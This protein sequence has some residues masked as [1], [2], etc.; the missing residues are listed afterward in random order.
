ML[1]LWAINMQA[2]GQTNKKEHQ[3][4]EKMVVKERKTDVDIKN[5]YQKVKRSDYNPRYLVDYSSVDCT[6]KILINGVDAVII[7]APGTVGG[8]VDPIT[9]NILKS[10]K[11][12]LK[13][14]ITPP[15]NQAWE[16]QEFLTSHSSLKFTISHGEFGKDKMDDY[17][18][19]YEFESPKITKDD[20]P[21]LELDGEFYAEVPYVLEGWTNSKDLR[22]IPH[23]EEKVVAVYNQYRTILEN[24]DTLAYADMMYKKELEVAKG[25]FW[26]RQ[27]DSEERWDDL[28][29]VINAPGYYQPIENY[30]LRFLADGKVV[31]LRRNDGRNKGQT[32][33]R[34]VDPNR[35]VRFQSLYLHM[36]KGSDQLEVI[37]Q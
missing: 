7:V 33:I 19:V 9:P 14:I 1:T 6:Y 16:P 29:E 10:G 34:R 2:C 18:V 31:E 11:Q 20:I 17:E 5:I 22:K 35:I 26:D 28:V 32:V 24:K 4:E 36:P 12:K 13:V 15:R 25:L 37:R 8:A 27:K 23:I 30:E 3:I 21:S